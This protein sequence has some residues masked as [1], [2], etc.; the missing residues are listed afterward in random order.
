VDAS[1]TA[2]TTFADTR[3]PLTTWFAAAWYATGTK[4]GVSAL[5]LQRVLGLGSYETAWALLHK[6]RRAMVR[7]GRDRLSGEVEVDESYVG[8]VTFR[9]KH[10]RGAERKTVVAI[11]VE[12][13]G[14]GMGRI[15]LGSIPDTSADSL[16]PFIEEAI[17][18]GS[19]VSTDGHLGYKPLAATSYIHDRIS[20]QASGDPG[21]IAM[22][23]VHRVSSLLK[24]WL[25]GTH[26]GAVRPQQLDYYLDE[27]TFRFNRRGSNHR[28]LL[29]YRL[30]EQAVQLEHVPLAAIAGGSS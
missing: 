22:P 7:P 16:L 17:E 9:G 3:L 12:K 23:R 10:G 15:R 20:I 29:F 8:G 24:R 6:F 13:R 28:G 5:S 25:L 14:R 21:H 1:I 19:V 18:P 11:A 2:G 27:F 30:L 26:Q 4:H